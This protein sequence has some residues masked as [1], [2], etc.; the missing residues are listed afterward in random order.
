MF[1]SQ[2][3]ISIVYHKSCTHDGEGAS[4]KIVTAF[5]TRGGCMFRLTARGHPNHWSRRW[6]AKQ[7]LLVDT[8]R[9]LLACN[10]AT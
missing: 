3:C 4:R 8:L 7:L 9:R 1:K 10:N 5:G 6:A 2:L